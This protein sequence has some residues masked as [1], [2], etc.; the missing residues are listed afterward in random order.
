[1]KIPIP[2]VANTAVE[3][4]LLVSHDSLLQLSNAPRDGRHPHSKD[5]EEPAI[6]DNVRHDG[7][8]EVIPL[9][10]L[11]SASAQILERIEV[12]DFTEE[13]PRSDD[14]EPD[15]ETPDETADHRDDLV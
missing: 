10:L 8:V 14:G 13:G 12:A 3:K 1:M 9:V 7:I 15:P 11:R 4:C 2:Q 5:E 6:S